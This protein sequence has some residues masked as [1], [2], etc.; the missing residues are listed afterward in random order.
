MN[1]PRLI[2]V[3]DRPQDHL[4]LENDPKN[5]D[6]ERA[7]NTVSQVLSLLNNE[8][9]SILTLT[10]LPSGC[11]YPKVLFYNLFSIK[12]T[13]SI[14]MGMRNIPRFV[15]TDVRITC[16]SLKILG[17]NQCNFTQIYIELMGG[18]QKV[19]AEMLNICLLK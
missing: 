10:G 17:H 12:T 9:R 13:I 11:L 19:L 14:N 5:L 4:H 1:C 3:K 15:P 6:R 16:H 18:A 8:L 7:S 2:H